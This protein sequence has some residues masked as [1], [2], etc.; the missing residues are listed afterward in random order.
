VIVG[1][2]ALRVVLCGLGCSD[3]CQIGINRVAIRDLAIR[4][5][6]LICS[7]GLLVKAPSLVRITQNYYSAPLPRFWTP[8]SK[9]GPILWRA[10]HPQIRVT[11]KIVG[12]RFRVAD[13]TQSAHQI[14][15]SAFPSNDPLSLAANFLFAGAG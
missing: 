1:V 4:D 10:R 2:L 6:A 9:S 15:T 7:P 13:I 11:V 12:H 5:S 14:T 3:R 8:F